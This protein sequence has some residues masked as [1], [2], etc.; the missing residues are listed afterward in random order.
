MHRCPKPP[1]R[2]AA[3]PCSPLVVP[4][5]GCDLPAKDGGA[6]IA[7]VVHSPAQRWRDGQRTGG[8]AGRWAG[9]DGYARPWKEGR[10]DS[11][12]S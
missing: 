3:P 8:Q 11:F 4:L 12:P 6:A 10:Q 5:E 2:V 7:I 1:R 9:G